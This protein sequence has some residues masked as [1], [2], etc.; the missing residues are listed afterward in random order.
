MAKLGIPSKSKLK[1]IEKQIDE[2]EKH[3]GGPHSQS[4]SV[5][6]SVPISNLQ[7]EH[8]A[9]SSLLCGDVFPLKCEDP[10]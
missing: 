6:V 8:N 9:Y 5:P 1:E 4:L 3:F 2:T 7:F 10:C